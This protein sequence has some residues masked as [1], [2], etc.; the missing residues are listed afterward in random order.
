M[1]MAAALL[2]EERRRN[3]EIAALEWKLR[4][5]KRRHFEELASFA[6]VELDSVPD[7]ASVAPR[8]G[9]RCVDPHTGKEASASTWPIFPPSHVAAGSPCGAVRA[10]AAHAT[11][12]EQSLGTGPTLAT[13]R[14][15]IK[16]R[17][18]Q[19]WVE[20]RLTSETTRIHAMDEDGSW[21]THL[22]VPDNSL[23]NMLEDFRSCRERPLAVDD[24]ADI[25]D[26]LHALLDSVDF[27][28]ASGSSTDLQLRL[29]R[30]VDGPRPA[31]ATSK[32]TVGGAGSIGKLDQ[33]E[34]SH[35]AVSTSSCCAGPLPHDQTLLAGQP[36]MQATALPPD[37]PSGCSAVNVLLPAAPQRPPNA[38]PVQMNHGVPCLLRSGPA[39][40]ASDAGAGHRHPGQ[41]FR[42]RLC[43][44]QAV[45]S[46]RSSHCRVVARPLSAPN[47]GKR[48]QTGRRFYRDLDRTMRAASPVPA[49]SSCGSPSR[50][51][52][53][54]SAKA[55]KHRRVLDDGDS[56]IYEDVAGEN[57]E[58]ELGENHVGTWDASR[59][60]STGGSG[61]R[62]SSAHSSVSR[63][64]SKQRSRHTC[65]M[66]A[67]RPSSATSDCR[68]LVLEET[69]RIGDI[70]DGETPGASAASEAPCQADDGLRGAHA[71]AE[72][73]SAAP[74][75]PPVAAA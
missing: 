43:T 16:A 15:H 38:R 40:C 23:S 20:D 50:R 41:T 10:R 7:T 39:R 29:P 71:P 17:R 45:T 54:I 37:W 19:I 52:R 3:V 69:T 27:I 70:S 25:D 56:I 21:R 66:I 18:F 67:S 31:R 12:S 33:D 60:S 42:D 48:P 22:D 49:E 34:A 35:G 53:P 65:G 13:R 61:S 47:R 58:D 14:R 26:F 2:E 8:L 62:A 36:P 28:E 74:L 51:V 57:E 73:P 24:Q 46:S 63:S 9:G 44:G 68:Q 1:Q 55:L 5:T 59:R 75:P 6:A 11:P 4:D 30:H 64:H 32:R 72:R